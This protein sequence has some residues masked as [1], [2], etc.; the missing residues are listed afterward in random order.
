MG[1]GSVAVFDALGFRGIWRRESSQAVLNRLGA[2]ADDA[3]NYVGKEFGDPDH[4]AENPGNVLEFVRIVFLS[5]T[6]VVGVARKA[7]LASNVRDVPNVD[8]A[9]AIILAGLVGEILRRAVS[10]TPRFIYRGCIASGE[11]DMKQ[12]FL[13]GPAIDE[14]VESMDAAQGALVWTMPSTNLLLSSIR[15][16][17]PGL[18]QFDVPLKGGD[19]FRTGVVS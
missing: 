2:L 10:Q 5:D 15:S 14:A 19:T 18:V 8:V 12:N 9:C 3:R 1:R 6:V 17:I 11:F 13:I 4:L 7:S 16:P